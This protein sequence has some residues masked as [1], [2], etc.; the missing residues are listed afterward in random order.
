MMGTNKNWLG[1]ETA[2][3]ST[4]GAS[5]HGKEEREKEDYYATDPH[6]V[7]CLLELEDFS[8]PILEPAC[9][10]GHISKVLV[11]K[12]L[13]VKSIDKIDRGYGSVDNFL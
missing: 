4:L 3:F 13:E 12:G 11:N 8:N 1:N 9:G 7:E 6:A 2:V 5:S 10:E